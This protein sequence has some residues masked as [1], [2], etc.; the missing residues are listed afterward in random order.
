MYQQ[1]LVCGL[2]RSRLLGPVDYIERL[3]TEALEAL[4]TEQYCCRST[5]D[6]DG[7]FPRLGAR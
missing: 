1:F 4:A 3:L 5:A 6:H 7:C 2:E